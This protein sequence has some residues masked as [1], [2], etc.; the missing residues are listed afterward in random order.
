MYEIVNNS[1]YIDI[2]LEVK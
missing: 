2:A 1:Q